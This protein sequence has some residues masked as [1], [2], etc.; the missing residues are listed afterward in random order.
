MKLSFIFISLASRYLSEI[1]VSF[2]IDF[3][4]VD[5]VGD[6]WMRY[7]FFVNYPFYLYFFRNVDLVA[8]NKS[9]VFLLL[10]A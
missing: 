7:Y 9:I 1:W 10:N 8:S 5:E 2:P 6:L 4:V 3:H